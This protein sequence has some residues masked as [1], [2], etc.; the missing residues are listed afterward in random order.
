MASTLPP[1]SQIS[2]QETWPKNNEKNQEIRYLISYTPKFMYRAHMLLQISK[3]DE[4]KE[5]KE[6]NLSIINRFEPIYLLLI[7][8]AG[9]AV[10]PV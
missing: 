8:G 3:E 5:K 6:Y 10:S 7:R 1:P 2:P 9:T 4:K